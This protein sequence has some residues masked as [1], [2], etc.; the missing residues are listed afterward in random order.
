MQHDDVI[1]QVINQRFCSFKVKTRTQTFCRNEYN[2]TG[3][4]NRTSCPL[5]NS[6]YATIQEDNGKLF[7]CMK[8]IERAHMPKKLWERVELSKSYAE[9]LK[10]ID[11]QLEHWP[12]IVIHKCKQRLTKMTQYLVR[13]R[14]LRLKPRPTLERVHKKVDVREKRREA[15]AEKAALLDRAI[16]KELLTRLQAGTYGDIYNFPMKNYEAA[17]DKEIEEAEVEAEAE[18]E[19]FFAADDDDDSEGEEGDEEE[20]EWEEEEEG[21]DEMADED[22]DSEEESGEED[23]D[24]EEG[25]EGDAGS[26]GAGPASSSCGGCASASASAGPSKAAPV[27]PPS[28]GKRAAASKQP[29]DS[30]RRRGRREVEYEEERVSAVEQQLAAGLDW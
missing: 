25:G 21:F 1:W 22:A 6:Q 17:L 13:M 4:C 20:E 12:Q 7:L 10:M 29:A 11:E 26:S 30:K 28:G 9:S 23:E 19:T 2:L 18:E 3:L 16:E 14:R 8:T 27:A 5:A 15:K 24:S